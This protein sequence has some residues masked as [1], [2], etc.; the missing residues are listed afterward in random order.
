M[1]RWRRRRG[2]GDEAAR[3]CHPAGRSNQGAPPLWAEHMAG[4][5][6][7]RES[8]KERQEVRTRVNEGD[9]SVAPPTDPPW[10]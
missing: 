6:P 5:R 8:V 3:G 1:K 7:E 10:W 4:K 9:Q 2:D